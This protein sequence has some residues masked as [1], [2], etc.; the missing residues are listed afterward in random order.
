MAKNKIKPKIKRKKEV[1]LE[2]TS[3]ISYKSFM[4]LIK[5][6]PSDCLD[7]VMIDSETYYDYSPEPSHR[8]VVSYDR[9]ETDEEEAEREAKDAADRARWEENELRQ[10]KTL[11]EKYKGKI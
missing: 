10:L 2:K 11:Q 5:E 7:T 8:L 3:C 9:D 6:V 4:E 1:I